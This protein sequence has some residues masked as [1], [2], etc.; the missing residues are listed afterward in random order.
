MGT[1]LAVLCLAAAGCN[2]T[3]TSQQALDSQLQSLNIQK[4]ALGN[5]RGQSHDRQSAPERSAGTGAD[6]HVV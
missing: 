5:F 4:E 6:R 1:V 3:Q 2:N